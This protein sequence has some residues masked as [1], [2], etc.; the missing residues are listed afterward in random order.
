MQ[1]SLK[2]LLAAALLA[3]PVGAQAQAPIDPSVSV[4]INSWPFQTRG[5]GYSASGRA[6]GFLADFAIDFPTKP[7]VSFDDYLVWCIDPNRSIS[8]PGGPYAYQ[9]YSAMGFANT[10]FGGANGYDVTLG[11]MGKIV[12]LVS[13]LRTNWASYSTTERADRQGSVWAT[14]RGETPVLASIS[15]ASTDGWVVLYDGQHQTLL[16]YVPEPAD[17]AL[18]LTAVFG[19]VFVVIAR[20]RRV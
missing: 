5:T 9:A 17:V 15:N 4:S 7:T 2:P 13:D 6:G 3:L 12:S 18:M 10:A 16:T 11:D 19:M 14:F 20:R 8:V 1:I